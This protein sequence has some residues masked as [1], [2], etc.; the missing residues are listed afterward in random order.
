MFA[1]ALLKVQSL[2]RKFAAMLNCFSVAVKYDDFY[3]E[4]FEVEI[5]TD[6]AKYFFTTYN[7]VYET[8]YQNTITEIENTLKE[9]YNEDD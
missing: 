6:K 7:W 2:Q 5:R 8:E 9:I 3:E 4:Y 1:E